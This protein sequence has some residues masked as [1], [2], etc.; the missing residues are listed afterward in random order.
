MTTLELIL[1]VW[2]LCAIFS[3]VI[4]SAKG[5]NAP[6]WFFLD[7]VFGPFAFIA[8]AAMPS[9]KHSSGT[10]PARDLRRCPSCAEPIRKEALVCRFC[11]EKFGSGD[12][13]T[14]PNLEPKLSFG[15]RLDR[16]H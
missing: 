11:G 9:L 13:A 10:G 5:R 1:I 16:S 2:I 15:Q 6:G 3:A 4:A 8:V 7:L 14:L 12:L